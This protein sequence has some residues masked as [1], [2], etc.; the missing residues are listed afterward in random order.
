MNPDASILQEH[1]LQISRLSS[2]RLVWWPTC[3]KFYA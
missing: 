2:C 3:E 1:L